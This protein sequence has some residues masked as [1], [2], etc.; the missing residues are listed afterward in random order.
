VAI[1]LP[2]TRYANSN[3]NGGGLSDNFG[4]AVAS[5]DLLM[6]AAM[7]F[8]RGSLAITGLGGTVAE[9][10]TCELAVGTSECHVRWA[11]CNGSSDDSFSVTGTGNA[12]D[13][14]S[15]HG[16]WFRGTE[17][18]SLHAALDGQGAGATSAFTSVVSTTGANPNPAAIVPSQDNACIVVVAA[19]VGIDEAP[20]TVTNYTVSAGAAGN[21]T[22]DAVIHCATRILVGGGGASQDPPAFSAW[23]SS[24]HS[25]FTFALREA[26]AA[27]QPAIKR[28][29]AV[30]F[31]G[32]RGGQNTNLWRKAG[33]LLLP[34]P[35]I[36]RV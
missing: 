27:G 28:M 18:S 1:T 25:I 26:V 4:W 13:G 3:T 35:S 2:D 7:T 24:T 17:T 22:N 23:A 14:E 16:L 31:S 5:G 12:A 6:L 10:A 9:A 19:S 34:Q 15:Y 29:G 36:I 21:D 30:K 11:L 20:G 8:D 32:N 33:E